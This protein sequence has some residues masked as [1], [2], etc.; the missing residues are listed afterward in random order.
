MLSD[1]FQ[2]LIFQLYEAEKYTSIKEA[3]QDLNNDEKKIID[4]CIDVMSEDQLLFYYK[5]LTAINDL[6]TNNQMTSRRDYLCDSAFIYRC[7]GL[8]GTGKSFLQNIINAFCIHNNKKLDIKVTVIAPT[9][10]IALQQKGVTVNQAVKSFCYQVLKINNYHLDENVASKLA[11]FNNDSEQ[12]DL[13][14]LSLPSLVSQIVNVAH[15]PHILNFHKLFFNHDTINVVL[16][17]EGSLITSLSFA[18][19]LCSY[20]LNKTIFVLF[21]GPNQLPPVS[22]KLNLKS[23]YEVDWGKYYFNGQ[24]NCLRT[25]QRFSSRMESIFNEYVKYFSNILGEEKLLTKINKTP[26]KNLEILEK[27]K[28]FVENVKIGGT[29]EEYRSCKTK[30][31]VLIVATNKK[32]QEENLYRLQNEGNGKIYKIPAILQQGIPD[33]YDVYSNLGIDS[34]LQIR[35]GAVC[36]CR[37]NILPIGLVKGML[38]KISNITTDSEGIVTSIIVT[39]Q[40]KKKI[41]NDNNNSNDNFSDKDNDYE[42]DG[43]EIILNR[44]DFET[45]LKEKCNQKKSLTVVQFPITLG[46]AITAHSAQGKTLHCK[47][48]IDLSTSFHW[49]LLRTM[50]F[51]SITRVKHSNQIYMNT[52]PA[53]WLLNVEPMIKD[54]KELNVL[55]NNCHENIKSVLKEEKKKRKLSKDIFLTPQKKIKEDENVKL[56]EEINNEWSSFINKADEFENLCKESVDKLTINKISV[57]YP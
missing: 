55:Y 49:D 26:Q 45:Q 20:P 39:R 17:D 18:L 33:N 22:P 32:R 52:H 46:Y 12:L 14:N 43:E 4:K 23:C 31:K 6:I 35:R 28:Y 21:C 48:G 51:V 1:I 57:M 41:N 3:I 38:L 5:I 44:Y 36:F 37:A 42:N 54:I 53:F 56:I 47:V 50:F 27:I 30:E 29:L 25:Q 34:V 13:K 11:N 10:Y 9:N 15:R 7:E 40:N 24:V 16:I 2:T 19:I 8:P